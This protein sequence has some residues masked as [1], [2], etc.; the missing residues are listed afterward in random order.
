M[1]FVMVM[2]MISDTK[3]EV[4][5]VMEMCEVT[6]EMEHIMH[7]TTVTCLTLRSGNFITGID[8]AFGVI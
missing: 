3:M 7:T 5:V 1:V 4:M 8:C 6:M 2:V